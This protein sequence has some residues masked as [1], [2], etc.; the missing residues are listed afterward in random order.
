M[1]AERL[2]SISVLSWNERYQSLYLVGSMLYNGG[3]CSDDLRGTSYILVATLARHF[4]KVHSIE[5]LYLTCSL[6]WA[7]FIH[8]GLMVLY[9]PAKYST[10]PV[11]CQ[12]LSCHMAH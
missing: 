1:I 5:E 6:R 9:V 10:T 3:G 12:N 2:L 7:L 11:S 4:W 8:L